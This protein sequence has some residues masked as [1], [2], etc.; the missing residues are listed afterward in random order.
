MSFGGDKQTSTS[1]VNYTPEQKAIMGAAMPNILN[2]VQG[3]GA[4]M[5]TESKIPGFN[6]AQLFAQNSQLSNAQGNLTDLGNLWGQQ[7]K[8]IASDALSPE[9]NPHLRATAEGAVRP[10][11]DNLLSKVLPS[12]RGEAVTNGM[13]GGTAQGLIENQA[14]GDANALAADTTSRI[15]SGGYESGMGRLMQSLGMGDTIANS[16]N[17]GA[18][19]A[20]QVGGQQF[21]MAAAKNE[22][23]FQK[24]MYA[25]LAPFLASR[26]GIAAMLQGGVSTST[27]SQ[28]KQ[29]P[30]GQ[31]LGGL[32]TLAAF[33]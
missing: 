16:T 24:Q 31:V 6:A 11:Y 8:F 30:F 27:T 5:P 18:T 17:V 7:A 4:K 19:S 2:Y 10:I 3:G 13:Y 32:S 25:Q 1:S 20:N 23:D 26:E 29:N 22:E 21:G 12:V 28:T 14:I 15:Y 9:S 33:L